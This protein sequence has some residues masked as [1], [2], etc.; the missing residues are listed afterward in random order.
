MTMNLK[1]ALLA[2]ALPFVAFAAH[3]QTMPPASITV[4]SA[5]LN[6]LTTLQSI[7][8]TN[9]DER[10][11]LETKVTI[12]ESDLAQAQTASKT[13]A[14]Q[15]RGETLSYPTR[16]MSHDELLAYYLKMFKRLYKDDPQ[17]ADSY[18]EKAT[19]EAETPGC[20]K[21]IK[22]VPGMV[23]DCGES[24]VMFIDNSDELKA[25]VASGARTLNDAKAALTAFDAK[26]N[27][28]KAL[29]K[30]VAANIDTA[31]A[32]QEQ[33]AAED[34][35]KAD[36]AAAKVREAQA[37]ADAKAKAEDV[38]KQAEID[39]ARAQ[40]EQAAAAE[41]AKIEQA[42]AAK[43]AEAARI[44]QKAAD[45]LKA[46]ADATAAAKAEEV[47]AAAREQDAKVAEEIAKAPPPPVKRQWWGEALQPVHECVVTPLSPADAVEAYHG[48]ISD[49]GEAVDVTAG[50]RTVSFYR[51][52]DA[53]EKSKAVRDQANA[54]AA[55]QLDKYR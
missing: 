19:R 23:G 3:A 8:D 36:E 43:R 24:F 55:R 17:Q 52:K 15:L 50:D 5:S 9:A 21:P 6:D 1:T 27:N 16:H 35:R 45:Q 30:A 39:Q 47:R 31:K 11:A 53:C 49:H 54:A 13:L 2:A 25:K 29:A 34:Q 37:E 41:T 4:D 22:G 32:Q 18:A 33:I 42:A 48:L 7:I 46:G 51:T 26:V 40:Q 44:R 10:D 38:A 20:I 12:A 14:D 28:T